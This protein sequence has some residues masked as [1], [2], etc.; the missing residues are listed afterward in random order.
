MKTTK[1]KV[2]PLPKLLKKAQCAVNSYV[3]RRDQ[4]IGCIS[5]GCNGQVE[6]AGHYFAQGSN[7]AFRFDE[8]NIHGCCIRCNLFLSG[9]LIKYRQGL[10]K[11][12]GEEYV[13]DLEWREQNTPTLKKWSRQDLE[14]I[15]SKY[16]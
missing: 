16:K 3:R 2:T 15:I 11:R 7:S 9:N 10:V 1:K 5:H 13:R 4:A 14:E 12:Y 8:T 6:N